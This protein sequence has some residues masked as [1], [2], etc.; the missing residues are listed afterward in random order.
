MSVDSLA[1]VHQVYL[2]RAFRCTLR[3]VLI[4]IAAF[5]YVSIELFFFTDTE[6]EK[7]KKS[8]R[9]VVHTFPLSKRKGISLIS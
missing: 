5:L 4:L 8:D 6:I 9:Q 7:K 1:S 3:Y 2:S